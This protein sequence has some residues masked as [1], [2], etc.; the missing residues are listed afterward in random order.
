MVS[1]I[2]NTGTTSISKSHRFP[3]IFLKFVSSCQWK[4]NVFAKDMVD[5]FRIVFAAPSKHDNC[6]NLTVRIRIFS[7]SP[8]PDIQ[9]LIRNLDFDSFAG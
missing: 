4:C 6:R 8:L 2:S 9:G 3:S 7:G 1:F 5:E